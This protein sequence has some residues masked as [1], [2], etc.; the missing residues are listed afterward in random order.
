MLSGRIVQ[1][2]SRIVII[3]GLPTLAETIAALAKENQRAAGGNKK[4]VKQISAEA[5]DSLETRKVLAKEAGWKPPTTEKVF[6]AH[7]GKRGFNGD[8]KSPLIPDKSK[9]GPQ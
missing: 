9:K 3:K 8:L 1:I 4:A 5:V 6:P 7:A 2:K